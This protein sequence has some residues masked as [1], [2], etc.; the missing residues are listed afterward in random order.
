MNKRWLLMLVASAAVMLTG[1]E[2]LRSWTGVQ[3]ILKEGE[4]Q[5][6]FGPGGY[7][8]VDQ[9]PL[10]LRGRK[11][12]TW[13][14]PA[15]GSKYTDFR[16]VIDKPAKLVL[17]DGNTVR[18]QPIDQPKPR[19]Q[20]LN[21]RLAQGSANV[22]ACAIPSDLDPKVLYQYTLRVQR[23]NQPYEVDPTMMP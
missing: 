9:E 12:V 7:L 8:L 20:Q 4:P 16:M 1:C 11:E 22:F 19:N 13:T 18:Y 21:C 14:L 23:D 2:Q 15:D 3:V 5:V 6:A 17:I 10:L